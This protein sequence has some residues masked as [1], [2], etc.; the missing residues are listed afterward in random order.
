MIHCDDT[1]VNCQLMCVTDL[2][3]HMSFMHS[4]LSLKLGVTLEDRGTMAK[5]KKRVFALS[6]GTNQAML[7]HIMLRIKSL[8]EVT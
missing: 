2:W 6:R 1:F 7:S 8:V 5:V 4:I 3:T